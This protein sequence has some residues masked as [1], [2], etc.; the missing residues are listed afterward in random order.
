MGAS[1]CKSA[2]CLAWCPWVFCRWS[3]NVF[4]LSHRTSREHHIEGSCEFL[5]R[6][7]LRFV[8]TLKS[9][10]HKHCDN[11]D[12]VFSLSHMTSHEHI[13][14]G[15][16][17]F[18]IGSSSQGVTTFQFKWKYEVFNISCNLAKSREWGFKWLYG[19]QLFMVCHYLA[20]YGGHCS[21]R[22]M[23]LV[24]YVIKQNHV[25]KGWGDDN[26]RSPWIKSSPFKV[27]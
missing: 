18:M 24:C 11:G 19:W 22:D 8:T 21:C 17:E 5:D 23:F 16:C 20:K 1:H 2:P 4:S 10:D 9:C 27:S 7:P 3:Y 26:D 13:F 12:N 25:I 6:S 14:K 15:L